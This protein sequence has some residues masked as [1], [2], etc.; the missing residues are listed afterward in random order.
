MGTP[1]RLRVCESQG[2][3]SYA[4]SPP[5]VPARR[6]AHQLLIGKGVPRRGPAHGSGQPGRHQRLP[7]ARRKSALPVVLIDIAKGFVPVWLFPRAAHGRRLRG[8]LAFGAAAILGHMFSVWVGFKG[9]RGWRRAPVSSWAWPPGRCSA[10][11]SW[12]CSP[13]APATCRSAPSA[14]RGALPLVVAL[15]PH[16]GGS[17]WSGS[18]SCWRDLRVWAHRSNVR[19]LVRGEENRFRG[20]GAGRTRPGGVEEGRGRVARREALSGARD[21]RGRRKPGAPPWRWS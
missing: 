15:T 2:P 7:R 19:R 18:A 5:L 21:R 9:G 4:P 16:E 14:P 1:I 6:D 13:S 10:S 3:V 12:W 8:T 20:P 17:G 11:C